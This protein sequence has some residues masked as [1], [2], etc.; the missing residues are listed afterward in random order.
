MSVLWSLPGP[1]PSMP[2]FCV[3][4]HPGMAAQLDDKQQM[5]QQPLFQKNVVNFN[6]NCH[7]EALEHASSTSLCIPKRV[8]ALVQTPN[9]VVKTKARQWRERCYLQWAVGADNPKLSNML[10]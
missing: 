5:A 2:S 1:C 9:D 6:T 4:H 10:T 3:Q 7:G 8:Q